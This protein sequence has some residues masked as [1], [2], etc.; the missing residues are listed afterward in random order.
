MT[1]F[2]KVPAQGSRDLLSEEELSCLL[3]PLVPG[4]VQ[5][6][7]GHMA[8]ARRELEQQ[9][10]LVNTVVEVVDARIPRCSRNPHLFP[11][12]GQKTHV[13]A[14]TKIDLADQAAT[15]RW[16]RLLNRPSRPA[17]PINASR[18]T[19]ISRLL[20][21]LRRLKSP[22]RVLVLGIPNSGKSSLINRARGGAG[23]RVGG[24]P[25]VTRG[26][27]W[28]RADQDIHFLDTPGLLWPKIENSLTGLKLAWVGSVGE[29]AYD[30][31]AVAGA[32]AVWLWVTH[33]R[34]LHSRYDVRL[35]EALPEAS[36]LLDAVGRRRGMLVA[37]DGID[38]EQAARALL[39]DLRAGRLGRLTLDLP[40][41]SDL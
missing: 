33:P 5:W 35:Q 36:E 8:K 41:A 7:P 32:L 22:V 17:L 19:G 13:I 10:K 40:S 29:N 34:V 39:H 38:R 37:G 26:P 16:V 11:L 1:P 30:V 15:S 18:G 6:F 23:A 27:Q 14:L 3:K 2:S 31:Q 25:G 12:I 24:K 4:G 9:L 28:L 21:T 20:L